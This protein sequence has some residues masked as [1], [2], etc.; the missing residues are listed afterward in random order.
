MFV[1]GVSSVA[2][3]GQTSP[4]QATIIKYFTIFVVQ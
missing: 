3:V 2:G 1:G 4:L